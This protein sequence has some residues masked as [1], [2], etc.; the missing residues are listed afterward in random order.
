[1]PDNCDKVSMFTRRGLLRDAAKM[2]GIAVLA[3]T[4]AATGAGAQAD[5]KITQA[6]AEYQSAPKNGQ[7]C[8]D[9]AYFA[10]PAACTLVTG[11]VSR[12]GWCKYYAKKD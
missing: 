8:S 9:C 6:A 2:G 11:T 7:K 10:S 5:G 4:F 1:M 12:A 3:Q